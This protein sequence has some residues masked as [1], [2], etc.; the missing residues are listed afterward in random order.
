MEGN[1]VQER[2]LKLDWHAMLREGQYIGRGG[3]GSSLVED[4]LR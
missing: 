1:N 3:D 2:T 4:G